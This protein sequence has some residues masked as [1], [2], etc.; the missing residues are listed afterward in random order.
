MGSCPLQTENTAGR[1]GQ[2]LLLFS[3]IV[4]AQGSSLEHLLSPSL[5]LSPSLLFSL[6]QRRNTHTHNTLKDSLVY[7]VRLKSVDYLGQHKQIFKCIA[8]K[9]PLIAKL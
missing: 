2:S 5:P 3:G 4:W 1:A 7:S 8:D 6:K 9:A